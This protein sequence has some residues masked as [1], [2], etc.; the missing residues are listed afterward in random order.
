MVRTADKE[1]LQTTEPSTEQPQEYVAGQP[2]SGKPT[3]GEVE[4]YADK[5]AAEVMTSSDDWDEETLRGIK[6]L[7]DAIRL[8][9]QVH[10]PILSADEEL[11]DGFT[12]LG[13]DNKDLLVDRPMVVMSWRFIDGNFGKFVALRVLVQN[14]DKSVS[15]Y[16]FN[17]GSTGICEQLAKYQLRT[18][19]SG[20]LKVTKGLTRS[21]YEYT[22]PKTGLTH[23]ASTYYLDT[24]A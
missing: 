10:G 1:K 20:G 13:S 7:D 2:L 19:R 5:L 16:I 21:D 9:E 3:S 22:D 12:L 4:R 24:S 6:S 14:P 8:T 17:D 23:P 18:G 11:G 15:R